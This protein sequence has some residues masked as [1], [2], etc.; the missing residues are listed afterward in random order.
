[1]NRKIVQSFGL[2]LARRAAFNVRNDGPGEIE[3]RNKRIPI[4]FLGT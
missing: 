1:V 2:F 3:T 4:H